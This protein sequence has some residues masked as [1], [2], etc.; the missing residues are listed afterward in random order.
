MRLHATALSL[1]AGLIWGGAIF[2]VAGANLI[3]PNYGY[4]F[5]ELTASIYPGYHLSSSIG[6][7]IVGTLYGFV[8]GAIGGAVFAWIYNFLAHRLS[9]GTA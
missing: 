8:D 5:L 2:L 1:T 7:V 4:A 6:S 9:S 3:W